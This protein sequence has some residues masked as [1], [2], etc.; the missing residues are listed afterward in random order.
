MKSTK[1]KH[2]LIL[3]DRTCE[4]LLTICSVRPETGAAPL[5]PGSGWIYFH[6]YILLPRKIPFFLTSALVL[7][8]CSCIQLPCA[9]W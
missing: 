7:E 5:L 9:I 2:G 1:D 3:N 4:P 6:V 8:Q